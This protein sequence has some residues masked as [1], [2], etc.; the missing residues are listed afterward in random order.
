MKPPVKIDDLMEEWSV[1]SK[2]DETEL[3]KELARVPILH[4]KYLRILSHHNLIVKKYANDFNRMKKLKFEYYNGDLNNPED[5]K[6]HG[7]EP[8]LKKILRQDINMYLESD[9]DLNNILLKKMVHQ[10]IVD[11]CTSVLR[12][13]SNRT[14][15]LN[16]AV[17]WQIFAGGH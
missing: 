11:F 9:T 6:E 17:K 12:E 15:Q 4:A 8:M 14:F 2:M 10:E 5:L 13:L 3:L 7:F 16:S 1:D